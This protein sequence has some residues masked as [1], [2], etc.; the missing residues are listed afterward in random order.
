MMYRLRPPVE[1]CYILPVSGS[2]QHGDRKTTGELL[3]QGTKLLAQAGVENPRR[4][5]ELL[6]SH[7]LDADLTQLMFRSRDRLSEETTAEYDQ[8]V[9]RRAS[10]EPLQYIVGTT[11]FMGLSF[12]VSPAVLIPRPE[13]EVLVE[14]AVSFLRHS[15]RV[16]SNVLDAGTGSGNIALSLAHLVP[17]AHVTAIDISET[18]LALARENQTKLGITGV[19][20]QVAD[21]SE[22]SGGAGYDLIVSNPPYVSIDDFQELEPEIRVHEPTIATTDGGD[23]LC[24]IR[25]LLDRSSDLLK[26]GGAMLIEIGYGQANEAIRY[27]RS[28]GLVQA[29]V[30]PDLA[31]IPR[32]L[33][34]RKDSTA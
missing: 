10:R 6:L 15:G 3:R 8:L 1:G 26:P 21:L 5:A 29:V 20:F 33:S 30:H 9:Q 18:A 22:F 14:H 7:L 13:T 23:G 2:G 28:A 25:T 12:L 34:V 17:G 24:I 19:H 4:N 16:Q 32:V 31:G 27:A 11:G